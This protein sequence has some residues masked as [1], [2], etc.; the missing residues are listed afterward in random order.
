MLKKLIAVLMLSA[1]LL[2]SCTFNSKNPSDPTDTTDK[3]SSVSSG[4]TEEPPVTDEKPDQNAAALKEK[5]GDIEKILSCKVPDYCT[6]SEIDGLLSTGIILGTDVQRIVIN[7]NILFT[8]KADGENLSLS[9]TDLDTGKELGKTE[10]PAIFDILK[11]SEKRVAYISSDYSLYIID[12]N[13]NIKESY[14][15]VI[16]L[17]PAEE[18][19]PAFYVVSSNGKYLAYRI[20]ESET[21]SVFS[22]ETG[23]VSDFKLNGVDSFAYPWAFDD[24]LKLYSSPDICYEINPEDGTYN[25]VELNTENYIALGEN[26]L[27][28]VTQNGLLY[29]EDYKTGYFAAID[30]GSA[31][32]NTGA[33]HVNYIGDGIAI[34][35][36]ESGI[37][38]YSLLS[39]E[40]LFE[41]SDGGENY[42]TSIK[43]GNRIYI[44]RNSNYSGE[45]E[46]LFLLDPSSLSYSSK[47]TSIEILPKTHIDS[48]IDEMINDI[49]QTYEIDLLVGSEGNDFSISDYVAVAAKD[50]MKIYTTLGKVKQTLEAYPKGMFKEAYQDCW[51]GLRIYLCGSIYGVGTDGVPSAG[52]V[53]TIENGYITIAIDVAQDIQGTL[54]HELSHAFD[55]HIAYVMTRDENLTYD[56]VWAALSPDGAYAD[57]YQNY[58]ELT[59]YTYLNDDPDNVW[60][61][62]GYSRTHPTEDRAEIFENLM[63]CYFAEDSGSEMFD[64][65]PHLRQKAEEYAKILRKYFKSCSDAKELSWEKYLLSSKDQSSN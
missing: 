28:Y 52:G 58:L 45:S 61:V 49:E 59:D 25:M 13:S 56:E 33:D 51:R 22:T 34:A 60:F 62:S 6:K 54:S 11:I 48:M 41:I 24:V 38:I 16:E 63:K 32:E 4:G 37:R 40:L 20:Y 35:D 7:E 29:V 30:F 65:C 19:Y 55:N 15:K 44:T 39:P 31:A 27:L 64:S 43:S 18:K 10:V 1:I 5:L 47:E 36:H 26:D 42:Y 46:E 8:V 9:T 53:T 21:I 23:K 14:E 2:S 50:R 17:D 12:S 57:S 3:S